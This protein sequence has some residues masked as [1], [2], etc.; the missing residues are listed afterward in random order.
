M[1]LQGQFAWCR[2]Q[3][4]RTLFPEGPSGAE[5]GLPGF[6]HSELPFTIF[7]WDVKVPTASSMR[8]RH[9]LRHSIQEC[10]GIPCASVTLL[11]AQLFTE[12]TGCLGVE[13]TSGGHL[14]N[15]STLRQGH[16][17]Q[18]SQDFSLILSDNDSQ[19]PTDSSQVLSKKGALWSRLHRSALLA[20]P[21]CSF[22]CS[23]GTDRTPCHI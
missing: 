10:A 9:R 21:H 4:C 7:L 19:E 2:T 8:L 3:S 16:L 17:E 14:F 12:S 1:N 22:L 18:V 11:S 13:G 23:S 5:Q 20:E 15:V 6:F